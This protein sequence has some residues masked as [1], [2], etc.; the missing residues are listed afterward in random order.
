[1]RPGKNQLGAK[2]GD[3]MRQEKGDVNLWKLF[4]IYLSWLAINELTPRLNQIIDLKK[5]NHNIWPAVEMAL[6]LPV[7]CAYVRYS[8]NESFLSG[9]N[10]SFRNIGQN[11]LWALLFFSLALAVE[12]AFQFLVFMPIA[13]KMVVP[14]GAVSQEVIRPFLDRLVEYLYVVYE[15]II[16]VLV[17]IG[18]LFDRLARKWDWKRALIVSNL[19]FALWHYNYWSKGRLEGSLTVLMVFIAGSII[20]LSYWKTRNTLS[21]LICHTLVDFPSEIRHLMGGI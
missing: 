4:G 13:Q 9:F 15:G 14:S 20:T 18:F 7:T 2:Y 3:E 10:L 8:E 1:M 5:V 12:A 17:F 19:G 21:P 16:E 6:I 11:L